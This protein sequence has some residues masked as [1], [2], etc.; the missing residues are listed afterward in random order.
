MKSTAMKSGSL[1]AMRMKILFRRILKIAFLK[2]K[3]MSRMST[4]KD[5]K[6]LP[7]YHSSLISFKTVRNIGM[8]N[9]F[10]IV[11]L[12]ELIENTVNKMN[13]QKMAAKSGELLSRNAIR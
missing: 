13:S 5:L 4:S 10:K 12:A 1:L 2:V 11:V 8:A 7:G 9:L 6:K 3:R